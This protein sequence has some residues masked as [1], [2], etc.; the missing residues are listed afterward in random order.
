MKK[1]AFSLALLLITPAFALSSDNIPNASLRV[2]VQQREEGKTSKGLHLLELS[3]WDG[4]CSL[5]S[6]SLNQCMESGSGQKAF[7]PAVQYSATWIGNL[8][9][10]NERQQSYCA[11]NWF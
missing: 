4:N 10:R 5:T 2:T 3:C 9:V 7:Y 8:K 1:W 6:V 11:R